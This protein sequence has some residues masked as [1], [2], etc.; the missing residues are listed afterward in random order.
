VLSH[1]LLGTVSSLIDATTRLSTAWP[2][3][4]DAE[5]AMLLD[6][7]RE[8]ACW[9]GDVLEGLVRGLPHDVVVALDHQDGRTRTAEQVSR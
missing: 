4:D 6:S 2:A 1:G 3:L 5:R 7:V 8:H 9:I